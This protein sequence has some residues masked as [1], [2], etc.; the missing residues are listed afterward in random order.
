MI[1]YNFF[2]T[3]LAIAD[4]GWRPETVTSSHS[5]VYRLP[6]LRVFVV[7]LSPSKQMPGWF[8]VT[9]VKFPILFPSPLVVICFIVAFGPDCKR[10]LKCSQKASH[11]DCYYHFSSSSSSQFIR[12]VMSKDTSVNVAKLVM[13]EGDL[14]FFPVAGRDQSPQ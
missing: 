10:N 5:E 9:I 6:S 2:K 8:V 13:G 12:P 4:R 11:G 1:H 7:F 3:F 14:R